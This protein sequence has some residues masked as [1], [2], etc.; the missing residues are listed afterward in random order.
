MS[1]GASP[2]FPSANRSSKRGQEDV[3]FFVPALFFKGTGSSIPNRIRWRITGIFTRVSSV[4]FIVFPVFI[5]SKSC[6]PATP[7]SLE[8]LASLL[9]YTPCYLFFNFLIKYICFIFYSQCGEFIFN[10]NF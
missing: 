8:L 1:S 7:V 5:T 4:N 10:T 6:D 3:G 2:G 9:Y